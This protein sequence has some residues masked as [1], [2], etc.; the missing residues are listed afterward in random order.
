MTI[1]REFISGRKFWVLEYSE[2]WEL[3]NKYWVDL[4]TIVEHL[5]EQGSFMEA[6]GRAMLL[7]DS[8]NL[9]KLVYDFDTQ[10]NYVLDWNISKEDKHPIEDIYNF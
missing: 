7:A 10:L 1:K 4:T 9:K 2:E 5:K 3:S 8:Y 6:I